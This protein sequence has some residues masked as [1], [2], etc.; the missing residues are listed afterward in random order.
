MR[1]PQAENGMPERAA[2]ESQLD[3]RKSFDAGDGGGEVEVV[4]RAGSRSVLVRTG[5]GEGELA[6]HAAKRPHQP[7]FVAKNLAQ[8]ADWILMEM[9]R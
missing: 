7:D 4:Y 5:F 8:A 9:H 1:L 3:L 6:W 2:A